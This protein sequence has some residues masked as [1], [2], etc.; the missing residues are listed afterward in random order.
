MGAPV[1]WQGSGTQSTYTWAGV[2]GWVL[3]SLPRWLVSRPPVATGGCSV[4]WTPWS[5]SKRSRGWGFNV[6]RNV[7]NQH[8]LGRFSLKPRVSSGIVNYEHARYGTNIPP[9]VK[10]RQGEALNRKLKTATCLGAARHQMGREYIC[11]P[12][13]HTSPGSPGLLAA[14]HHGAYLCSIPSACG[15]DGGCLPQQ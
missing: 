9:G 6:D 5:P 15:Q 12:S 1:Q 14:V 2:F 10:W 11:P 4:R 8:F 13:P 3:T 7:L